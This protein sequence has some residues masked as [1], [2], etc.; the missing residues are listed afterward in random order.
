MSFWLKMPA[1]IEGPKALDEV[2]EALKETCECLL[3]CLHSN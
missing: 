1:T 3:D 2:G